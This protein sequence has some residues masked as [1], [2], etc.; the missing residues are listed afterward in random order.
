VV[1]TGRRRNGMNGKVVGG[2]MGGKRD[3]G[4]SGDRRGIELVR[5]L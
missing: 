2:G 3:R 1:E 4:L 5:E